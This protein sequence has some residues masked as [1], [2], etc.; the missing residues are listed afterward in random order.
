MLARM[1]QRAVTLYGAIEAGGTKFACAVARGIDDLVATTRIATAGPH[2][3]FD[4]VIRF[5]EAQEQQLG[6]VSSFGMASFGPLDLDPCSTGFGRMLATPKSG[7]KHIDMRGALRPRFA[8]PVG[9]DTDVNAA[10][11]AESMHESNRQ[12]RSLVYVTVG[13]GIGGGAVIDGV[14][15]QGLWHTEMG[16][17][18]IRRHPLDQSFAGVCPFHRDCLE[19]LAN[20]PA[21]VARWGQPMSALLENQLACEIIGS[22]LGQLARS[23]VLLLAPERIVFGGGVISGGALLPYIRRSLQEQLAGYVAHPSLQDGMAQFIVTPAW[24]DRSGI[25]GAIVLAMR[26][27]ATHHA[28]HQ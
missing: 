26:A 15:L 12:L 20:G 6:P 13:T 25:G 4:A 3:T 19:G 8:Q 7:W 1:S 21:I 17:I 24:G 22:Y 10:A 28:A 11:L 5:F 2:E 16:H 18:A 9:I 27:A 14:S 23:L